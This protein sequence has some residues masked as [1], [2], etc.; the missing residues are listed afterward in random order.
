MNWKWRIAFSAMCFITMVSMVY[1]F[2]QQTV[3]KAA[4][5]DAEA[6]KEQALMAKTEADRQRL[7][8]EQSMV[9]YM[10]TLKEL[11]ELKKKL[12]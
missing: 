1:A 12:K 8:A 10:T 9:L 7:L 4:Q 11:E 3:A 5:R 2:V 6:Q